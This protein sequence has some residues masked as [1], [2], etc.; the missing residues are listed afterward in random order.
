VS[1]LVIMLEEWGSMD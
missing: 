1:E